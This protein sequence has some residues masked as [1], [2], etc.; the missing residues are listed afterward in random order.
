MNSYKKTVKFL[1]LIFTAIYMLL[2]PFILF[3]AFFW[4]AASDPRTLPDYVTVFA[5]ALVPFSV[6]LSIYLMWS[7]YRKERYKATLLCYAIP[8]LA[9][10]VFVA[11]ASVIEALGLRTVH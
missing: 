10:A 1:S 3:V 5:C 7:N 2:L 11:A 4:S 9:F 6:P 8:F